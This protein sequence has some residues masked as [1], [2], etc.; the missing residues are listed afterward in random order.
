MRPLGGYVNHSD[1]EFEDWSLERSGPWKHGKKFQTD[2]LV[3]EKPRPHYPESTR[4]LDDGI[5][6]LTAD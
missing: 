3:G 4:A 1:G 5:E 6:Q 2:G